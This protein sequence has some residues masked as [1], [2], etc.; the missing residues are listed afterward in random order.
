[1]QVLMSNMYVCFQTAL[2]SPSHDEFDMLLDRMKERIMLNGETIYEVGTG[3]RNICIYGGLYGSVIYLT[4][5]L[6]V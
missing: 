4:T 5:R 3:G 2:V 1:M 6:Y